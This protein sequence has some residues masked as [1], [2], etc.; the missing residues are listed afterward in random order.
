M[1][2]RLE[3]SFIF[4]NVALKL[5]SIYSFFLTWSS[6]SI[7]FSAIK[8][9]LLLVG[10][11]SRPSS[12]WV[13]NY[14]ILSLMLKSLSMSSFSIYISSYDSSRI[15]GSPFILNFCLRPRIFDL[16]LCFNIAALS[17]CWRTYFVLYIVSIYLLS[18]LASSISLMIWRRYKMA[19]FFGL[20]ITLSR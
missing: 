9:I 11:V 18:N 16:S 3:I 14:M 12:L 17:S 8:Y 6:D 10:S 19:S 20:T 1:L 2:L 15:T 4:I 5:F 7:I 13:Y